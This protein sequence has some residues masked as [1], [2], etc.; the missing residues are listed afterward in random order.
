MMGYL[1]QEDK[2]S[3][4]HHTCHVAAPAI[5]AA[6]KSGTTQLRT[7]RTQAIMDTQHCTEADGS[8]PGR[9]Q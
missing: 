1:H 6:A 9:R 8:I 5:E 4:M 3:S 2:Q 7:G